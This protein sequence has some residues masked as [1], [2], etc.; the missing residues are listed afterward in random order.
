MTFLLLLPTHMFEGSSFHVA[1]SCGNPGF[2]HRNQY[3]SV[4][5]NA[6]LR[7]SGIFIIVNNIPPDQKEECKYHYKVN[8]KTAITNIRLYLDGKID[9]K[10]L[11][12]RIKKFLSPIRPGRKYSRNVKPQSC[13]TPSYYAA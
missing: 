6:W 1:L 3:G 11:A 8:F 2:R 4:G 13:K 12:K 7:H 10:E 5:R 9:E